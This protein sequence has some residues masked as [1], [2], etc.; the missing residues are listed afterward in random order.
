MVPVRASVPDLITPQPL[1]FAL[2]GVY[3]DDPVIQAFLSAFDEVLA[4]IFSTLDNLDSYFDPQL[5]PPDFLEWLGGWVG[6]ALDENWPLERRRS[7]VQNA[8]ELYRWRGTVR[9]LAAHV[10]LHTG[11]EPEIEESGGLT[12]SSRPGQKVPGTAESFVRVRVRVPDPLA[13]NAERLSVMIGNSLPADIIHELIL[14]QAVDPAETIVEQT[15]VPDE[16]ALEEAVEP[17]PVEEAVE[18]PPAEQAKA[19]PPAG[20]QPDETTADEAGDAAGDGAGDG[21]GDEG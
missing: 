10:A 19:V 15:V 12:W 9:G 18:P 11:V 20:E 1:G 8:V 14:E 13:I 2:P 7:L 5:T 4:P 17:P 6:M 21:A 16:P 3:H